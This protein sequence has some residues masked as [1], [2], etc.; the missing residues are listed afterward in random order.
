[1]DDIILQIIDTFMATAKDAPD[2]SFQAFRSAWLDTTMPLLFETRLESEPMDLFLENILGHL[3]D[4]LL[5]V[6]PYENRMSFAWISY[7]LYAC[8]REQ[9]VT[10]RLPIPLA[11]P[12]WSCYLRLLKIASLSPDMTEIWFALYQLQK[13][14][15]FKFCIA[16][17]CAPIAPA[18][19][20]ANLSAPLHRLVDIDE[21]DTIL[22]E[23]ALEAYSYRDEIELRTADIFDNLETLQKDLSLKVHQNI[24][25]AEQATSLITESNLMVLNSTQ[26]SEA[27]G[28]LFLSYRREDDESS[29]DYDEDNTRYL[30]MIN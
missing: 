14:N 8:Y 11:L 23:Y 1:M 10:P 17:R 25:L 9:P 6:N 29:T 28:S 13:D 30:D 26:V 5:N 12:D 20:R 3:I 7:A 16:R 15:C 21:L 27:E 4:L 24:V 19:Q 18:F 2:P 22:A